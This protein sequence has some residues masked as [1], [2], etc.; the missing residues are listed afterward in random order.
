[1]DKLFKS[2]IV[3]SILAYVLWFFQPYNTEYFYDKDT[4]E[5]LQ[6]AGFGGNYLYIFYFSYIILVL[7]I[8]SALGMLLYIKR[9]RQLFTL[10]TI[11]NIL[12]VPLVGLMVTT[13]IDNVLL[14]ITGLSDGAVLFMA[15]FS[16]ISTNF[17]AHNNAPQPTA[18]SGG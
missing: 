14:N 6:W 3:I 11:V 17:S 8:I 15:Y 18:E 13:S 9:A 10:L 12:L 1:M 5:A 7:Y 2:L 16:S 4:I